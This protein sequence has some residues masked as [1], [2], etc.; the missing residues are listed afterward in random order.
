MNQI[1]LRVIIAVKIYNKWNF[2]KKSKFIDEKFHVLSK[3]SRNSQLELNK[4]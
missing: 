2:L 4:L 3:K 1:K